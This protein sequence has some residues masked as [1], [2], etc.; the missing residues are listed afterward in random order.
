ML[1]I[2][3]RTL[4]VLLLAGIIAGGLYLLN[5]SGAGNALIGS[6]GM[7]PEGG[8]PPSTISTDA[9]GTASSNGAIASRPSPPT[10]GEGEMPGSPDA[11]DW[12]RGVASV[13]RNLGIVA[14][15]T[16]VVVALQQSLAWRARRKR[17]PLA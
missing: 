10:R 17:S 9:T 12:S 14:L 16:V 15:F 4:A 8:A 2:L 1:R 5:A 11:M 13:A 3:G 7:R 6:D